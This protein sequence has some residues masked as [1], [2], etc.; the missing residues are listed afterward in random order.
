M[1][2]LVWLPDDRCIDIKVW[3]GQY[4]REDIRAALGHECI[5]RK[6]LALYPFPKIDS[7]FRD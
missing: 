1:Q 7:V 5:R 2:A 6:D 4:V 3:P